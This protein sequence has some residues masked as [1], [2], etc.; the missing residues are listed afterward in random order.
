MPRP[1]GHGWLQGLPKPCPVLQQS[2]SRF[3]GREEAGPSEAGQ[4]PQVPSP[5]DKDLKG[6]NEVISSAFYS[7]VTTTKFDEM[8]PCSS[9]LR[10]ILLPLTPILSLLNGYET[11]KP[12]KPM[13]LVTAGSLLQ[14]CA[15][16]GASPSPRVG[17][18]SFNLHASQAS[19]LNK[20]KWLSTPAWCPAQ[21]SSGS[22]S[23]RAF[24]VNSARK[25]KGG[26]QWG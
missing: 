15:P 25:A 1:Q 26:G 4:H 16:E 22:S 7:S 6:A 20:I 21:R 23:P 13:G 2:S 10:L 24:N 8:T 14:A 12:Q 9:N 19:P 18:P 3:P 5:Q 17:S 11:W